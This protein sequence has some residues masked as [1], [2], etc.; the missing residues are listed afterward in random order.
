[1]MSPDSQSSMSG[2]PSGFP[3]RKK[4]RRGKG[5]KGTP[6]GDP[7]DLHQKMGDALKAGNHAEA[8]A[9]AFAMVRTLHALTPKPENLSASGDGMG[10]KNWIAGATQS[11]GAL[12][13][14]LG[15][16]EG[17]TIPKGE[18]KAATQSDD[19]KVAREARLAQTLKSLRSK[20]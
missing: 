10:K 2:M 12:H 13:R 11:K 9:H 3:K 8:K 7:T 15:V 14:A 17:Q 19:V 20:K 18:I 5:G 1:M 16:P 6:I 4:T